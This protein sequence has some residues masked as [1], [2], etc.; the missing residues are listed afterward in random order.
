MKTQKLKSRLNRKACLF[1]G[2]I[3]LDGEEFI[4]CSV[5]GVYNQCEYACSEGYQ[6]ILSNKWPGLSDGTL[7][8]LLNF[9]SHIFY[10]CLLTLALSELNFRFLWL[11]IINL[12]NKQENLISKGNFCSK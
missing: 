5:R 7:P 12:L 11:L 9:A 1:L 4:N 10:I 2:E 6:R 8:C 3:S